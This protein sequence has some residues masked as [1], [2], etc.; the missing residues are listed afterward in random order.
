MQFKGIAFRYL[1]RLQA[2]APDPKV[3]AVLDASAQA[4]W[5][6][7]RDPARNVFGDNW[8]GP[9]A[10]ASAPVQASISATEALSVWAEA[11]GTD[12]AAAPTTYEAEES[13]LHDLGLEG[14]NK[15]F[16]GWGYVAGWHTDGQWIDFLVSTPS[17]GSYDAELRYAAGAGDASRQIYVN[18]KTIVAN[19]A[20]PSTGGW[21]TYSTKTVRVSLPS[22]PST[23]SVI[24][25]GSLGSTS[26]L[27]L[28]RLKLTPAP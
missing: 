22:G 25:A 28:D 8:A 20:F 5:D 12:P 4:I 27:N 14:S 23:L 11:L 7:A 15:G 21:G 10:P 24:Y 17:A 9:A 2:V 16:E 26:Y 19:Q 6:D 13:V 1:A 3:G 18:G